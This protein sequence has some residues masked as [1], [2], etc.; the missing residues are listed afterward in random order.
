MNSN[1]ILLKSILL[2]VL[3][4]N[5]IERNPSK[6]TYVEIFTYNFGS[7]GKQSRR[8]TFI[9]KTSTEQRQFSKIA[10]WISS[11][12]G[13]LSLH[14]DLVSEVIPQ[15]SAVCSVVMIAENWR[16]ITNKSIKL[17][18]KLIYLFTWF[19]SSNWTLRNC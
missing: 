3:S 13:R 2:T 5:I 9:G 14:P 12:I 7:V 11:L 17:N 15:F 18:I 1:S 8:K 4:M 16:T 10:Y 6:C 19:S